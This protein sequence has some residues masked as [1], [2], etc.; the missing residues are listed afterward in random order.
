MRVLERELRLHDGRDS[1]SGA[2]SSNLSACWISACWRSGEQHGDQDGCPHLLTDLLE[3]LPS[4]GADGCH[5]EL[6]ASHRRRGAVPLGELSPRFESAESARVQHL[7]GFAQGPEDI[8]DPSTQE[9]I[10]L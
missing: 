9:P 10:C 4:P 8:E 7:E 2:Q 6:H 1:V 3:S 5:Y